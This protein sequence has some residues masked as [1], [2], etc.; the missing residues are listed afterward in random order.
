M[1]RIDAINWLVY[2]FGLENWPRNMDKFATGRMFGNWRFVDT[3]PTREIM[4]CNMIEPG[5]G[6]DEAAI[7]GA[8]PFLNSEIH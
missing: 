2:E 7:I 3:L 4:F 5:I 1:D 6:I 8:L